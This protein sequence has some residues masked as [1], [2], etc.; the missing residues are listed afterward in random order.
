MR[1]HEL[2]HLSKKGHSICVFHKKEKKIKIKITKIGKNAM[3]IVQL[4]IAL[5]CYIQSLHLLHF[6]TKV[7]CIYIPKNHVYIKCIDFLNLMSN[8]LSLG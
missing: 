6:K 1:L 8:L 2:S 3:N 4:S 7:A 5:H